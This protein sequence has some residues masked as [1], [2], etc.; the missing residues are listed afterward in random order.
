ME[1]F[2]E[3]NFQN[4]IHWVIA[5]GESGHHARPMHPEWVRSLRDQCA[6]AGV[7]FFFK[8]W[9]EWLPID[10]ADEEICYHTKVRCEVGYSYTATT[11]LKVGKKKAGNQLYGQQYL[12]FPNAQNH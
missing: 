5:G 11:M 8:Q 9:G 1:G 12:E 6:T 10:H 3:C 4:T 2:G 7:P